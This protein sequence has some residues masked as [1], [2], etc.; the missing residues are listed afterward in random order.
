MRSWHYNLMLSW[1]QN[2]TQIKE[3][4]CRI[5]NQC[6]PIQM[7]SLGIWVSIWGEKVQ[8]VPSGRQFRTCACHICV[9]RCAHVCNQ[10]RSC[11]LTASNCRK[12]SGALTAHLG[13]G[14]ARVKSVFQTQASCK[15]CRSCKQKSHGPVSSL[16]IGQSFGNLSSW[17]IKHFGNWGEGE[18]KNKSDSSPCNLS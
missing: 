10:R 17:E 2:D 6:Q 4:W 1:T 7:P 15:Q 3:D 14:Q 5:S 16:F 12:L 9:C 11:K 8:S 13:R 18:V